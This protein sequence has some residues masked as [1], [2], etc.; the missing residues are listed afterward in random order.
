LEKKHDKGKA[1]T[2]LAQ[3]WARTVY[4]MRKRKGAFDGEKF[5]QRYTKGRGAEEPE[6]S[7]DTKGMTLTE[8]LTHAACTASVNAKAPIG[9]HTLS[10]SPLIGPPLSLLWYAAIVANGLRGL[11]LTR[12]WLSLDN[13]AAL[14][15]LFA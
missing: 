8:A 2:I 10:P 9:H 11:L 4:Y 12:T 5:C 3:Q 14:R 15:P 13:A 6:A 7:R 1:L